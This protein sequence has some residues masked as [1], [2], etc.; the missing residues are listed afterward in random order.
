[1]LVCDVIDNKVPPVGAEF[2]SVLLEDVRHF[3]VLSREDIEKAIKAGVEHGNA[4]EKAA[5]F[6]KKSR[7]IK[8]VGP[9]YPY[10]PLLMSHTPAVLQVASL[11]ITLPCANPR[12]AS[13]L[14]AVLDDP[15]NLA[16][17]LLAKYLLA[18]A[19]DYARKASQ[20][21]ERNPVATEVPFATDVLGVGVSCGVDRPHLDIPKPEFNDACF[22]A[23]F[24]HGVTGKQGKS[25][26]MSLHKMVQRIRDAV[27]RIPS[28]YMLLVVTNDSKL[29]L[30]V[31]RVYRNYVDES[32]DADEAQAWANRFLSAWKP[33]KRVLTL[34]GEQLVKL[35]PM[36]QVTACDPDMPLFVL[37]TWN[38]QLLLKAIGAVRGAM[39][40]LHKPVT[41]VSAGMITLSEPP[42]YA[43]LAV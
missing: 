26:A 14:A 38:S 40:R 30:D 9:F 33:A 13:E 23:V 27:W 16:N 12:I 35:V 19:D 18:I 6:A 15:A 39:R 34:K 32:Y 8:A 42:A 17:E 21:G 5:K 11:T 7:A 20:L 4:C 41:V 2:K 22:I 24:S 28:K 37:L 43:E 3:E 10:L 31:K 36:Q 1:M 25:L 29:C